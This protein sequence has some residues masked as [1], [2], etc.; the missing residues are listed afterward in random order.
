MCV[1]SLADGWTDCSLHWQLRARCT[2]S[3]HWTPTQRRSTI[4]SHTLASPSSRSS[5]LFHY[6]RSPCACDGCQCLWECGGGECGETLRVVIL[7]TSCQF[8]AGCMC[9]CLVVTGLV[10]WLHLQCYLECGFGCSCACSNFGCCRCNGVG[11]RYFEW[12][13]LCANAKINAAVHLC[14]VSRWVLFWSLA[15]CW[16]YPH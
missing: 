15:V 11:F 14:W 10:W 16:W 5:L 3:P 8:C 13:R 6:S 9:V 12:L 7:V 4:W 1:D 2:P